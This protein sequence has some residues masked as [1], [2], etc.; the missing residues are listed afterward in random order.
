MYACACV[1]FAMQRFGTS[2]PI[3]TH[4]VGRAVLKGDFKA[5]VELILAPREGGVVS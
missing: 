4:D 1:H 5:T 2:A 3:P